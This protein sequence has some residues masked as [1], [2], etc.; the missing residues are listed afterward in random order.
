MNTR[1]PTPEEMLARA[2]EDQ[3]I[4]GRGRLKIFF[5][6]APGVGKTYAMLLDARARSAEG[7][8]VVLGWVEPHGRPETEALTE[9]LERLPPRA[10]EYRGVT[11]QEFDL[12]K[13]LAR[14]PSLLVLDELA[15]TN[16]EGSRHARRWQDVEELL[17]AG[18]DVYTSL[19][20]QHLESLN[21]V[22]AQITGVVVRETVPDSIVDHADQ[23]ALIDL[24]SEDLL[25][26]LSEG[27]VYIPQQAERALRGFFRKGN[28]IALRELSLRHTAERVDAQ[29]TRYKRDAGIAKPW[30]VRERILAAI[31]PAPQS[32]NLIR[33]ACR[34]ATRLQAP[35]IVLLVETPSYDRLPTRDHESVARHL[36]LAEHLGAEIAVVRGESVSEEILALARARNVTR[37]L[38]GKPTHSRWRDRWRG[39]LID[40]LVRESGT[41]DVLITRGDEDD[42]PERAATTPSFRKEVPRALPREYVVATLVVLLA[43]T[44]NALMAPYIELA[45]Q[46]MIYLLAVVG[47]ASRLSRGP[48]LYAAAA[49]VAALDFCFVPPILTFAVQ[50]FRHIV[51]FVIMLFVGVMVST[52]TLRI[53]DQ[54]AAARERER[55]TAAM[56]ALSRD[57]GSRRAAGEIGAVAARHAEDLLGTQCVIGWDD[58]HGNFAQRAGLAQ[59]EAAGVHEMAVARWVKEHGR[60]AGYG[61]GTLPGTR[62]AYFPLVGTDRVLGV[63]GIAVGARPEQLTPSQ[64]QLAETIVSQTALALERAALSAEAADARLAAEA[65]GMRNALL[66]AV[67][68]DLRTPLAT[69]NGASG[70]LLDEHAPLQPEARREL[71]ETI[72]LEA[73]RLGR[74]VTDLLELSRLESTSEPLVKQWYPIEEL[75][76]SAVSRLQ[77]L[78][79]DRPLAIH[80]PEDV[81]S[82]PV[83]PIL[84]EQ[85]LINLI[86][87][88]LKYTPDGSPLEIEARRVGE[89]IE[90]GVLDRGPGIPAADL[91][92][93]FEKFYRGGTD[94]SVR[95]TG[96]GLALC[97]AVVRSHGGTISAENRDGG[98]A[99]FRVRLPA[100]DPPSN[101][102]SIDT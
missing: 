60:P 45:D 10:V 77:R 70:V 59:H 21:D 29:A 2:A 20:V 82:A 27:K 4:Q 47:V 93:I 37:L 96:L 50:D 79:R 58:E 69:I 87:N 78:L 89:Q 99:A 48:S 61:T 19:N 56:Y 41:I 1:R 66:S 65:E 91:G 42:Q 33:A 63:F 30:A 9:G 90:I 22:V 38:V 80:L 24:S 73:Q 84:I 67:S 46:T 16:A 13:A 11:L 40:T 101:E 74:I 14:C 97:H 53:R 83:E 94:R 3:D 8:D 85:V 25:Q 68:H 81:L 43:S 18:I 64:R 7:R 44:F 26:R 98:G 52:L 62:F 28:L 76:R 71:L 72:H 36:A 23:I 31:G 34:M 88:A 5:G 12:D 57:L 35:W 32:A 92:R 55:R 54:A 39:S 6:A 15:H 86:D 75:V 49:S 100:P 95:G 102:E 17:D 51:T